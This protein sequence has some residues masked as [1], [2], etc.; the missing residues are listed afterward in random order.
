MAQD[1]F[2]TIV[3][4]RGAGGARPRPYYAL[5]LSI[6]LHALVVVL[7]V[8]IP[9][10]AADVLPLPHTLIEDWIVVPAV[11]PPV[12]PAPP[13]AHPPVPPRLVTAPGAPTD[14]PRGIR[15]ENPLIPTTTVDLDPSLSR[16]GTEPIIGDG[17][18]DV[19]LVSPPPPPP[20]EKPLMPGGNIRAPSKI[21]VVQPIYPETA[22]IARIEGTVVIEAIIGKT[23]VV[24]DAHVVGSVPLLDQAALDAVRQW[25]FTPTLLN[26]VP[27]EVIMKVEVNFKL[28]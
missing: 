4:P 18:S 10:M 6:L 19:G 22:R 20:P 13:V 9:L 16:S 28:R 23:G 14:A 21:H 1:L 8:V 24:R 5:P 7:L 26:G 17:I 27:V 15:P 12:I 11:V 2:R 3:N 25:T